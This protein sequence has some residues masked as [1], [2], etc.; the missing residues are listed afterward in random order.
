MSFALGIIFWR[1]DNSSFESIRARTSVCLMFVLFYPFTSVIVDIIEYANDIKVYE[2]ERRDGCYEPLPYLLSH[3]IC[4]I[5]RNIVHSA[6]HVSIV[7]FTVGLR[8]DSSSLACF[9]VVTLTYV[10]MQFVRNVFAIVCVALF[11]DFDIAALA[12]SAVMVTF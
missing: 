1:T 11:R 3:V 12:A 10:A 8:T 4:A 9:G 5:P 7:F 2:R 6:V